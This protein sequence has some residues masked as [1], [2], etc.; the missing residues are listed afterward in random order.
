MRIEHTIESNIVYSTRARQVSALFDSPVE[1]KQRLSWSGDL[2]IEE[3][4]WSVGLIV[5]PSGCGKSTLARSIFGEQREPEWRGSSVIDDFPIGMSLDE[6]TKALSSVGFNTVPAWL[7]PYAVL[8]NGERFR[9][10]VAR[11][12]VEPGEGPIVIDEFTSVVDRQVARVASHAVQKLVR[13]GARQLVAVSCHYDIVDWLQPDWVLEPATMTF[14]WRSVRPRPVVELET[15]RVHISTWAL[16]RPFHYMTGALSPNSTCFAAHVDG[17]PVAFVA[18]LQMPHPKVRDIKRIS[19]AVTLPDW[20]GLG[21]IHHLMGMMGQAYAAVGYRVR[22]YPGHPS[23]VR[24]YRCPPWRL[25]VAPGENMKDMSSFTEATT[26]PGL[27]AGRACAVFEWVGGPGDFTQ[28]SAE[29]L[30]GRV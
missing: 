27:A 13:R 28:R 2:P 14:A 22:A 15:R 19:R 23:F 20:Q 21:I 25:E 1:E 18:M 11:R 30:L 17:R 9:V 3:R 4:P 10:D 24:S 7:R 5:G 29:T 26:L 6:I 8:S 12:L 16:F